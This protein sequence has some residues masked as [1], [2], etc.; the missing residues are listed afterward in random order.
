MNG[1]SHRQTWT[2]PATIKCKANVEIMK[3]MSYKSHILF[4]KMQHLTVDMFSKDY[5]V[6][7]NIYLQVNVLN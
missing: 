6:G 5:S 4:A 1:Q 7:F 2:M 3:Q